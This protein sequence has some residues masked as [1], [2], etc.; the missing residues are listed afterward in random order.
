MNQTEYILRG[1]SGGQ[2]QQLAA[3]L[4]P[5]LNYEWDELIHS[6]N[7]EG[8]SQTRK[9][10]PDIWKKT[11]EGN[12]I[13]IQVTADAR[14]GKM[15]EDLEKSIK[16]LMMDDVLENAL[17]IAF[18]SSERQPEEVIKCEKLCEENSIQFKLI[19]N[20][21]IARS[22]DQKN[23]QD[24]R[25]KY[26]GIVRDEGLN[27][28][29]VMAIKNNLYI[30]LI[31][32]LKIL[33]SV[34]RENDL[35]KKIKIDFILEII[36]KQHNHRIPNNFLCELVELKNLVE[37]F[38]VPNIYNVSG[39]I[40]IKF[41]I[42]GFENLY[43]QIIEGEIPIYYDD[44]LI[45]YEKVYPEEYELIKLIAYDEKLISGALKEQ[46]DFC[47][48]DGE[49][50]NRSLI[51][52]FEFALADRNKKYSSKRISN[53][54]MNLP[55]EYYIASYEDFIDLFYQ[56]KRIKEKQNTLKSIISLNKKLIDLVDRKLLDIFEK[57]ENV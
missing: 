30:P 5:R 34:C 3:S 2:L 16:K 37:L 6:G 49:L 20:N 1:L 13:Y 31:E 44:E 21:S 11:K 27:V 4:L 52:M 26:L 10:T 42:K 45:Y 47:E 29:V 36:E 14:Q 39:D 12:F 33:E 38:N 9:G 18:V 35:F 54:E 23:N 40:I 15:L 41:F 19:S 22:L 32:E 56:D 8:T 51:T 43:G 28:N 17:C 53:G 50:Y 55:P 24:L 48:Y 25:Q 57:Y 46:D 7:V